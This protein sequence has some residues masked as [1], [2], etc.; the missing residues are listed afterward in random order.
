MSLAA[1]GQ[2]RPNVVDSSSE[3]LQ[4]CHPLRLVASAE[5][6]YHTRMQRGRERT[7]E[8][9]VPFTFSE[10]DAFLAV[11]SYKFNLLPRC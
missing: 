10:G 1:A 5:N 11:F 6:T 9:G 2:P 8:N 7:R 3:E 4:L